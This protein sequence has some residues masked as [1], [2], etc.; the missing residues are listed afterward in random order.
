MDTFLAAL[1]ALLTTLP[2]YYQDKEEPAER[3]ERLTV[4]AKAIADVAAEATCSG[5]YAT[6][7][8]SRLWPGTEQDLVIFLVTKGFWESRFAKHVQ[9][10][11]CGPRECDAYKDYYTGKIV[12]RSASY[13][14]VQSNGLVPTKEWRTLTGLDYAPT[15]RAA[16]AAAKVASAGRK[17]CASSGASWEFTTMSAYASG[18]TC[19]WHGA[20]RRVKFYTKLKA[21]FRDLRDQA[22][23]PDERPALKTPERTASES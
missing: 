1:I 12:H 11:K 23:K 9:A 10:G 19:S 14:Q 3:T 2:S 13:F 16:W 6:E 7:S 15:R 20:Y 22:E 21:K 8:C 18:Y 17:R 4:I 5:A